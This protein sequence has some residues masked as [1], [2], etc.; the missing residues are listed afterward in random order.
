VSLTSHVAAHAE[1]WTQR[2]DWRD[3][4]FRL[5]SCRAPTGELQC[6]DWRDA[7][8]ELQRAA[9]VA[10]AA[11]AGTDAVAAVATDAADTAVAQMLQTFQVFE[12][13]D[14]SNGE[15]CC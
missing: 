7:I 3:A 9:P 1:L 4:R 5:E 11:V 8:G 12:M 13:F 2:S 10:A 6:S 14:I 15:I